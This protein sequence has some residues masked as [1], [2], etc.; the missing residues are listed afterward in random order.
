[1]I[2]ER[3]CYECGNVADHED[4]VTP[5]VC[6]KKCG[7]KDTRPI[8]NPKCSVAAEIAVAIAGIRQDDYMGICEAITKQLDRFGIRHLQTP[9][10]Q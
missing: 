3:K 5:Y 1:M 6:C 2:H 4:N 8:K 10:T 7:S 9:K